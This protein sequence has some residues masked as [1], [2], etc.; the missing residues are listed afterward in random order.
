VLQQ[1]IHSQEILMSLL[2]SQL[3]IFITL[4][5]SLI[6]SQLSITILVTVGGKKKKI[7]SFLNITDSG[8][9]SYFKAS[10]TNYS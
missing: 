10:V 8:G 1:G 9:C 2:H 4:R 7:L 5:L 6:L 3:Q